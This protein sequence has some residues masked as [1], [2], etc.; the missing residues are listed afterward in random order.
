[1]ITDDINVKSSTNAGD[2][3]TRRSLLA[4][5]A[6]RIVFEHWIV[7][8]DLNTV[9]PPVALYGNILPTM[10][11]QLEDHLTALRGEVLARKSKQQQSH[12]R[13]H[14]KINQKDATSIES[15]IATVDHI[16]HS[17]RECHPNELKALFPIEDILK[18][19]RGQR[20]SWEPF[21][22]L[23]PTQGEGVYQVKMKYIFS[24]V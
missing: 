10:K 17:G 22:S 20:S 19:M 9:E 18:V 7:L 1:M 21:M 13:R 24:H 23:L 3:L 8:P 6:L 5:Q 15:W 11:E 12:H 14:E 4:S 16:T 2:S